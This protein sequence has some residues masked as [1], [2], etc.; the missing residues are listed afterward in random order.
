MVVPEV[1]AAVVPMAVLLDKLA[2]TLHQ[3]GQV[4]KT[5]EPPKGKEVVAVLVVLEF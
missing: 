3:D 5:L 1:Q 2:Q 4:L